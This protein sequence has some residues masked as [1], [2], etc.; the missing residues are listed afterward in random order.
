MKDTYDIAIVGSGVVGAT[1]ALALAQLTSLRIA[2]IETKNILLEWNFTQHD[3]RVSAISL[4]SRN[5]FKNLNVWQSIS[6]KRISPYQ[7]MQV[8]DTN[9][10]ADIYFNAHEINED[11]LGF[12]IEDQVMRI[13]LLEALSQHSNVQMLFPHQLIAL[14]EHRYSVELVM[15]EGL[16]IHTKLLIAADGANSIV[17]E[18]LNTE[19]KTR[20]YGHT[21]IVA[22]VHSEQTHRGVARQQFLPAGPL[23]FL[24]LSDA[25]ACS[26]VWSTS[27]D[28][29]Q[30]LLAMNE[31]DF[32][33]ALRVAFK[34]RLGE[35]VKVDQRHHF[36]LRM[37][38]AK[39][40][41]QSRIA[42]IGDAAHTI[43]PL[44]GQ[45][46]NLGLLDAVCLAEVIVDACKKNRD[47]ASLATL[48]RYERWRKSDNLAMLVGMDVIKNLFSS[49]NSM[50]QHVRNVGLSFTNRNVYL[51]NCFANYALGKRG[52]LP[53]LAAI[54]LAKRVF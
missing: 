14:K 2:V 31:N 18:L 22:T 47:F 36:P 1:A 7:S 9:D 41:V 53:R 37:R 54:N 44:A 51:K 13:S 46:A 35:I 52:D 11:V 3:H 12:I 50:L 34:S 45:G 49:Q 21:A 5:I 10:D 4:A 16:S 39:H 15:K 28:H 6:Q 24:P 20:D 27:H 43:H 29:A 33:Q 38:H 17:R 42:L 26:I 23:A 30:D 40:Y 48:R 19:L 32:S 25:H 8:W